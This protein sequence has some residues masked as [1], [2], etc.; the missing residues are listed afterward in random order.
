MGQAHD[1]GGVAEVPPTFRTAALAGGGTL[2]D[3]GCH[4]FDLAR[5]PGGAGAEKYARTATLKFQAEVDDT[6]TASLHFVSGALGHIEAQWTA[7]GWEMSF[8]VY[9][10]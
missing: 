6:A 7:T 8:A 5:H 10:T 1:W 4:P 3:N 2:L 9:G